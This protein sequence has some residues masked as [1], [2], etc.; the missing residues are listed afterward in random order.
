MEFSI[1]TTTFNNAKRIR[2]CLE[3]IIQAFDGLDFEIVVVD[4]YS[5]DGSYE[6]IQE[7][8]QQYCKINNCRVLMSIIYFFGPDGTGKSTLVKALAS[9]LHK[10]EC[11]LKLSWMRGSHTLTSLL[12]SFM[13]KFDC[14]KGSDN[15]YYNIRI[16][17]SLKRLWQVLDFGFDRL[18]MSYHT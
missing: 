7:C 13:T 6:I 15:P 5:T 11:K 10:G 2:T 4:N 8:V 12:A 17:K 16:P 3:S 1:C 9:E 18:V 14:F